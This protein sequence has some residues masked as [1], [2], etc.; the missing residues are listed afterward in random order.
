MLGFSQEHRHIYQQLLQQPQ[1]WL[2]VTGPPKSGKTT[3]LYAS[4]NALKEDVTRDI[5]TI[6]DPIRNQLNGIK[7]IQVMPEAG[8]TFDSILSFILGRDPNI[9]RDPGVI[10]V[11]EIRDTDTAA[12]VMRVAETGH[13]VLSTLHRNDAIS[14]VHHLFRLGIAPDLIATNLLGIIAQRLVKTICP[15]CKTL[16]VP[17]EKELRSLGLHNYRKSPP[18]CCKGQGCPACEYTGYSGQTGL[19]EI[20]APN[21]ELRNALAK[22]PTTPDFRQL[23]HHLGMKTLLEDGIE[24]IRQGI[25]TIEEVAKACCV[26]CPG[27]EHSI[28]DTEETC[29]FCQ[30]HLHETCV[31][32]GAQLDLEWIV[33]P[34]CGTEKLR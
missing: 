32:C 30:Y 13:F 2:L 1:G 7:Q 33:C 31:Q 18:I 24:K 19:Y 27:C 14:A 4:L 15:E 5:V 11:E 3:T 21:D 20:F 34:F 9:H 10:F 17:D 6:E 25:T 22:R 12:I 16:Y 23:T 29:P 28:L 26:T 8:L